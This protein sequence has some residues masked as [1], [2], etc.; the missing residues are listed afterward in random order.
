MLKAMGVVSLDG[1]DDVLSL[2]VKCL[3]GLLAFAG[4]GGD[5]TVSAAKDGE[6]CGDPLC[7]RGHGESIRRGRRRMTPTIAHAPTGI[8]QENPTET[9]GFET[10]PNSSASTAPKRLTA[11]ELASIMWRC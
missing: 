7:D 1:F 2:A 10:V 11:Q 4:H 3:A 5:I 9:D 8:V 6:G